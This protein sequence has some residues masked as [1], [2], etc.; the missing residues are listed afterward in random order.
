MRLTHLSSLLLGTCL[1]SACG[2][3]NNDSDNPTDGGTLPP[4]SFDHQIIG[5]VVYQGAVAG[6][7]V[8]V[9]FNQNASCETNEPSG[10]AD[11]EGKYQ[12]DWTSN[13]E[14]PVYDLIANWQQ[15]AETA[16]KPALLKAAF[17]TDALN[18]HAQSD[19]TQTV[20]SM[21]GEGRLVA[22][23]EHGGEI[24]ALTNL[25]F[26]RVARMRAA[27]TTSLEIASQ[28]AL[29]A[30]MVLTIYE[31]QGN[32]YKLSAEQS[33]AP[34]FIDTYRLHRH[35]EALIG[36]QLSD[37]LAVDD[38]MSMTRDQLRNL[39]EASGMNTQDYLNN[40][41]MAIRFLVNNALLAAGYIETPIDEKI[42]S[43]ADWQ[44]IKNHFF[45]DDQLHSDFTLAPAKLHSAFTLTY[46]TPD[47]TF[48]G[49]IIEGKVNGRVFDYREGEGTETPEACWNQEL[50]LWV[51]H[52]DKAYQAPEIRYI[53][54]TLHTVYSSTFVPLT[55]EFTKYSG[56][57]DEWQ[58]VLSTT[59][60]ALKLGEL[61]WPSQVYRYHIKQAAD[62]MCR[63]QDEFITW[64]M[65]SHQDAE[66][67]T[68][69]DIARLFWPAFY[70]DDTVID[71]ENKTI[72]VNIT[73]Q[74]ETHQWSLIT[75]PSDEPVLRVKQIDLPAAYAD[76]V[77]A[78]DY[79]IQGDKLIEVSIY[80]ATDYMSKFGDYLNV[81]FDGNEDNFNQRFQQHL[82]AIV[83]G[84]QP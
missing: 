56:S 39:V 63:V 30:A 11:A 70:P 47:L 66:Q 78:D 28:R 31:R 36:D 83:K 59:P 6:A 12:I 61:S 3:S 76:M 33:L 77:S 7:E 68:T 41:P 26:Q 10:I 16:T 73:G 1:L 51:G 58:A 29:L 67:L 23:Q 32:P 4:A 52:D 24:N 74:V 20:I 40:D 34:E 2:D 19:N 17:R 69:A 5:T 48:I 8:C 45:E 55:V 46:G 72:K 38:I 75:G 84:Q 54:N 44:V 27:G 9:D 22:L 65:P 37:V 81:S 79:L 64:P 60:P 57:G 15:A 18:T 14:M 71:E 13:V 82:E 21:E 25:E 49:S 80:E 50:E 35:L 53:D 62:V 43:Y 42:M